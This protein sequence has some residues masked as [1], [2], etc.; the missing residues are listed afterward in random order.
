MAEE[1]LL[2]L[3]VLG[4]CLVA[5]FTDVRTRRIPN[6]LT[7]GL[8][9][10]AFAVHALDGW[11][12]LAASLAVF[13]AI[14][15]LGLFLFSAGIMGGGDVKLVAAAGAAFGYPDAA[16]FVIYTM[17]AGGILALAVS[18]FQ[19]R[20]LSVVRSS[21]ALSS[22]LLMRLP[23]QKEPGRKAKLPYAIAIAAGSGV[24]ILSK[25]AAPFLSLRL[26]L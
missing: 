22:T 19:R 20:T 3:L 7:F 23:I 16:S 1:M 25:S 13:A 9:G 24:L 8:A 4:V 21:L 18:A 2:P 14:F 10:V 11:S 6:W 17:L 5:V 26:P 15:L 12:A